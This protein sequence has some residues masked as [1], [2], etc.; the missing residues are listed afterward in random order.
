MTDIGARATTARGRKLR[1]GE[2]VGVDQLYNRGGARVRREANMPHLPFLH[3][4]L[5]P[6]RAPDSI[7]RLL[8]SVDA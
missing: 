7:I 5:Q 3:E 6:V 4:V 1:T 8:I 2:L